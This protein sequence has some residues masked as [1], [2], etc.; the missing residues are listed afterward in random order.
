MIPPR[1]TIFADSPAMQAVLDAIRAAL[2]SPGGVLVCGESGSGRRMVAREVHHMSGGG[3][4]PFVAVDCAEVDELESALFGTPPSDGNGDSDRWGLDSVSKSSLL[5]RAVGGTLFLAHLPEMPARVQSRLARVLRDGEFSMAPSRRTVS[6]RMRLIASTDLSWDAAVAEGQIRSDLCKKCSATRI[7][8]PPLR[9]RREDIPALVTMFLEGISAERGIGPK[10][11]DP[12]AMAL[13]CA[14]P[15]RGNA[16]ELRS[17]LDTLVQ[18]ADAPT[19]RLEDVLAAV[20]LDGSAKS[21]HE[22]GTLREAKE[23]F[24]RDYIAAVLERHRGRIAAAATA[25]GIQRPNLYRKMRALRLSPP[26][27]GGSAG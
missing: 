21:F 15:W 27:P 4:S 19:M 14:F 25:L 3:A 12:G 5:Y 2:A 23:R 17:L 22:A 1:P 16:R 26:R 6:T 10:S 7:N 8:V 24:E 20:H 18:R 9:D 13:L 11:V